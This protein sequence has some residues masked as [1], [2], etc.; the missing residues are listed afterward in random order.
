MN[1]LLSD[2]MIMGDFNLCGGHV[3]ELGSH[4]SEHRT[5]L[6][7]TIFKDPK[8]FEGELTLI[9]ESRKNAKMAGPNCHLSRTASVCRICG[10]DC[11]IVAAVPCLHNSR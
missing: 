3:I 1:I 8:N 11:G 4:P 5:F 6:G 7:K 2:Y 9:D 10:W